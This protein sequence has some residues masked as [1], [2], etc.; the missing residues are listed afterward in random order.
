MAIRAL[1]SASGLDL[2]SLVTQLVKAERMTKEARLDDTKKSLDSSLSG[3]G[4]L[5]SAMS[6][7]QDAVKALSLNNLNARTATV[8]QPTDT[9]TYLEATAKT[10]AAPGVFDMK[11]KTLAS[12]SRVESADLAFASSAS[13][14]STTA[15]E[16]TFGA[17]SKTFKINVT[18]NMTLDALRQAINS[19]KDNF[20]VSANIINAGGTVGTKL[21]LTS[22]VTG[23]GNQL[24]ITNNNAAL[25][26]ISTV[27]N[28]GGTAGLTVV[29]PATDAEVIIDGIS[30]FSK[31]NT[32]TNALQDT[33]FTVQN[34]TPDGN[35]ATLTIA[36]DKKG[37]EEKLKAFVDTYNSLVTEV[38][39]LTKNRVLGADGK[40]VVSEGGALNSDPTVRSMLNMVTSALGKPVSSAEPGLN[41]LYSLGITMT[42][43]GRLEING[44][45]IGSSSGRER[46]DAALK[47]NFDGIAKLFGNS[48]GFN[49]TI[50]SLVT[51]FTQRGGLLDN[52]ETSLKNSLAKNTKDRDAYTR[53]IE[54]YENTLRQRYGALD[55]QLGQLQG[56][57]AMLNSQLASLS[58]IR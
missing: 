37:T 45:K 36:T 44:T 17:G 57:S 7:F 20:G 35:N 50:T 53:Y 51:Q 39:M 41:N 6:K 54:S 10:T 18:A 13:V 28:S 33:E 23:N 5:K 48:D 47:D 22:S 40:T 55:S 32:F 25:D 49:A 2:E 12:G 27:P 34:V 46:L 16:L 9:K 31:T 19:N 8:K 4:K 56:T 58:S 26:G 11:V 21:V 14:V 29:K 52:K 42:N 3:Y 1:G 38:E 43:S 30:T 24:S 15:G